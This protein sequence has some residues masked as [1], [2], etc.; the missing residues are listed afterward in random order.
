[1]TVRSD[2][3]FTLVELLVVVSI[4]GLVAAVTYIAPQKLSRTTPETQSRQLQTLFEDVRRQAVQQGL[5]KKIIRSGN[6]LLVV[7][8]KHAH[9]GWFASGD[10]ATNKFFS[11]QYSLQLHKPDPRGSK[12]Y[13]VNRGE[14]ETF[15]DSN[16][17]SFI[18]WADGSSTGG[19]IS[20][21]ANETESR[22]ISVSLAGAIAI[23]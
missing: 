19:E 1:M 18:F 2:S 8:W 23:R 17:Q 13:Q 12:S 20:L 10:V 11:T 6:T 4:M 21:T 7:E 14:H 5:P 16:E 9:S 15:T 22:Y 3:G